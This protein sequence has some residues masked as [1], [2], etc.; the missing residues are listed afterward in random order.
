M[1]ATCDE[2]YVGVVVVVDSIEENKLEKRGARI[3]R[4]ACI[5]VTEAKKCRT[6]AP[7]QVV[8]RTASA[9]V[10]ET[11]Q[12][13]RNCQFHANQNGASNANIG[14]RSAIR[15]SVSAS[16][17]W[18]FIT[19]GTCPVFFYLVFLGAGHPINFHI[20]C[21][22]QCNSMISEKILLEVF[23]YFSQ[24]PSSRI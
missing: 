16:F 4:S 14:E 22:V 13:N 12:R 9:K 10:D 21:Q 15:T 6:D 3:L 5:L 1:I 18:H 7:Q 2:R 17:W 11:N 20:M 8:L 23:L 24:L 19:T